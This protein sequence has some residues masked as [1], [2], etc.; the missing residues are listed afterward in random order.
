VYKWLDWLAIE[1]ISDTFKTFYNCLTYF[2]VIPVTSCGCKRSFSKMS[3]VKTKL[4][5]TITQ[6]RFNALLFLFIE[7]EYVS[8]IN[9]ESVIDDFKN[10]S[11]K[12]RLVL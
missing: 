9:V 7:H 3:I 11:T 12:R 6:E 10:I 4:R 5:S 2:V 1:G 8:N